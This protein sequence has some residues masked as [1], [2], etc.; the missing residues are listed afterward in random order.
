MRKVLVVLAWIMGTVVTLMGLLILWAGSAEQT[1]YVD[2]AVEPPLLTGVLSGAPSGALAGEPGAFHFIVTPRSALIDEPISVQLAQ[3]VPGEEVVLRAQAQDKDGLEFR[4]WA[5]Y[6]ADGDGRLDLASVAPSDGT[7]RSVDASGLLWSMRADPDERFEH[8]RWTDRTYRLS[9]ETRNGRKVVELSRRYPWAQLEHQVIEHEDFRAELWL[10]PGTGL[11]AVVVLGG[12]SG[13]PNRLRSS[14]LAARGY[15]VLNLLYLE[16]EPWPPELIEVPIEKL[17]RAL[18][19]LASLDAVDGE[20]MGVYGASKGAEFALLAASRDPRIKAV[21]VWSPTAVVMFGISFQHPLAVRSSW[22]SGGNPVPFASGVPYITALRN[23]I[24]LLSGRNISFRS[25]YEAAFENATDESFIPIE[26]IAGP[27]LLLSGMDD[28]MGAAAP[29]AAAIENRLERRGFEHT[30]RSRVYD[31]AG[32]A[33]KLDLWP[34]GGRPSRFV[35]GGTPEA[36]H[37]AGRAA[38]REILDFF[39]EAF[40]QSACDDLDKTSCRIT[41]GPP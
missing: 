21:A 6:H 26:N 8:A 11:P 23:G 39:T 15:A 37:L 31:G 25:T 20:R 7:Y 12:S 38:W 34:G 36:N 2:P 10:P 13:A 3:L 40:A 16:T 30:L 17:T 27:I 33:M 9:A 32:H 28:Q 24:R 29:M 4:S 18:D 1:A 5:R 14:L 19:W 41:K 22:S 35:G